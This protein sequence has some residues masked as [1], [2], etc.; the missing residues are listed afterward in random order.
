MFLV[1]LANPTNATIS[2]GHAVGT[3]QNHE[4][5]LHATFVEV[6]AGFV[7]Y[8][9]GTI[10]PSWGDVDADRDV[11]LPLQINGGRA[12]F[13]E[14][15]GFRPLL[16]NGNYHGAAWADYDRDGKLDLVMPSYDSLA[17]HTLLV[18]NLGVDGFVDAAPALGMD[19][20]G[21]G[22]T[23]VWGDFDGDGWPDLFAPYYTYIFPY[24]CFLYHNNGNGRSPTSPTR[25]A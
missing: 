11:D 1:D 9:A 12:T 19:V 14:M 16:N 8:S 3:I 5:Q 24:Q 20:Q 17:T 4:R 18:H 21:H 10:A 22:E 13:S 15:P 25:R 7:P 23:P 6:N 2:D